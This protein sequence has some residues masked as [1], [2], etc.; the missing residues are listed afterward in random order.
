MKFTYRLVKVTDQK[1][2]NMNNTRTYDFLFQ[3]KENLNKGEDYVLVQG[4]KGKNNNS[5]YVK[6]IEFSYI[7]GLIWDKHREYTVKKKVKI[8]SP[9]WKRIIIGFEEG[10][11]A[12]AAYKNTD[13]LEKLLQFDIFSPRNPVE[14]VVMYTKEIKQLVVDFKDWVSKEVLEEKSISIIKD[15]M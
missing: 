3:P 2:V 9:E 1:V 12:L 6:A 5:I 14:D 7:E 11:T 15:F 10:I 8:M 4:G 13:N